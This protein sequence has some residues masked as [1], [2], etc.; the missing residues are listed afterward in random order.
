MRGT[1]K[2]SVNGNTW[3]N[4]KYIPIN[5]IYFVYWTICNMLCCVTQLW[6]S[7]FQSVKLTNITASDRQFLLLFFII[8][9]FFLYCFHH[10]FSATYDFQISLYPFII[11]FSCKCPIASSSPKQLIWRGFCT[12]NDV[13]LVNITIIMP[14]KLLFFHVL[15]LLYFLLIVVLGC[16]LP[17]IKS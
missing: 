1:A 16:C 17:Q 4:N 6:P 3:L 7:Y 5:Q 8:A 13:K 15:L 12:W 2:N 11:S 14:F 9:T 10:V